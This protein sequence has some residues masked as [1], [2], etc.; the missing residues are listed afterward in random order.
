[1]RHWGC[2]HSQMFV[3]AERTVSSISSLLTVANGEV[4]ISDINHS[5]EHLYNVNSLLYFQINTWIKCFP[6][7]ILPTATKTQTKTC[8]FRGNICV[9]LFLV[10][11][12]AP[13]PTKKNPFTLHVF[14]TD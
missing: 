7:V 11:E 2:V 14:G 6:D 1:M 8:G 3:F 5:F 9:T 10:L 12:L 4:V 13:R